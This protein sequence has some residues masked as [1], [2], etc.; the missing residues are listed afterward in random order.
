MS[1]LQ[2][3]IERIVIDGVPLSG[4]EALQLRRAL[5]VELGR[6]FHTG[7]PQ[8]WRGAAL[9]RLSAPAVTLSTPLRPVALGQA[10][11]RSVHASL[12]AP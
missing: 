1:G 5:E 7:G 4:Q 2:L 6:L 10:I 11:A 3:H 12:T 9:H 8:S